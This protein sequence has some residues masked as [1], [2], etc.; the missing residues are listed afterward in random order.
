[1]DVEAAEAN[2]EPAAS[3]TGTTF[4]SS[5]INCFSLEVSPRPSG[6]SLIQQAAISPEPEFVKDTRS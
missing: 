4:C 5:F 3:R 1:M 6:S 2:E